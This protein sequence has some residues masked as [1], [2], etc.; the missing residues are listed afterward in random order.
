LIHSA[1]ADFWV[2]GADCA[3]PGCSQ[4]TTLD[5]SSLT[6]NPTSTHWGVSYHFGYLTPGQSENTNGFFYAASRASGVIVTDDVTIAG[7]TINGMTFGMA[8]HVDSAFNLDGV[9]N[10]FF[11]L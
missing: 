2:A 4:S 6:L 9:L 11:I 1:A 3:D 10:R 8:A 5:N 7:L